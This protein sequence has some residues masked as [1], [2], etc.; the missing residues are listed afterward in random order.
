MKN[1]KCYE[2]LQTEI[3]LAIAEGNLSILVSYTE[4]IKL[5]YLKGCVNESMR[6]YHSV[7]LT[8]PRI[9]PSGRA[10]ICG[11]NI[12]ASYRV[13]MNPAVVLIR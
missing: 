11:I 3:D 7:G 8:M 6:L 2:K 4:S 12:L 1:P 10:S 5:S 9:V 13:R